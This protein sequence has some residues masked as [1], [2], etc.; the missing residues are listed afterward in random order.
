MIKPNQDIKILLENQSVE[1]NKMRNI[2]RI[3]WG[4]D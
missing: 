1:V 2:E 3:E 4:N